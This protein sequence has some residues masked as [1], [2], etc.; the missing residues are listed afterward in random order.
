MRF[1]ISEGGLLFAL[2]VLRFPGL[3]G[4]RLF[5]LVSVRISLTRKESSILNY[6]SEAWFDDSRMELY[7]KCG[8]PT[9][10]RFRMKNEIAS[11]MVR[12]NAESGLFPAKYA[13]ADC[14]FGS[15][16][17]FLDSLPDGMIYF[18]DVKCDQRVFASRSEVALP[19]YSGKGRK[20]VK[21]ITSFSPLTVEEVAE[22]E[23]LPWNDVVLGIGAKGSVITN[24]KYLRV[25]E[26]RDGKPGKDVWL[27]VRKSADGSIKYALYNESATASA[28]DLRKPAL[29]RWSIEQ[30]FRE[31]RQT[32]CCLSPRIAAEFRIDVLVVNNSLCSVNKRPLQHTLSSM[33]AI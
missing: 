10:L 33:F 3:M 32:C 8:T 13:G 31:C 30:C 26:V 29:M 14:S 15:D 16:S 7:K 24:D 12:R 20:P 21:E 22:D 28:E 18:V 5:D 1:Q 6:M 17:K 19:P 9:N 2:S 27:Y 4:E 23:S 11:C 25:V